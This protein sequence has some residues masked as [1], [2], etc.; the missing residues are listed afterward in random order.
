MAHDG[1]NGA[2]LRMAAILHIN[3][4]R[5]YGVR[6][7]ERWRGKSRGGGRERSQTEKSC[8]SKPERDF[9]HNRFLCDPPITA[10]GHSHECRVNGNP[11]PSSLIIVPS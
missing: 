4:V 10:Y 3:Y 5:G 2:V 9:F 11:E 1:M 6:R 7:A 8:S